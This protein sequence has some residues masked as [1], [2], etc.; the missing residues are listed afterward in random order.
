M[1]EFFQEKQN[2]VDRLS[3]V[4]GVLWLSWNIGSKLVIDTRKLKEKG[5]NDPDNHKDVVTHLEPDILES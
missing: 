2:A 5:L 3:S 4:L 1:V